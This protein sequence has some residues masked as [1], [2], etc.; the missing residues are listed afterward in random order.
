MG[1]V[2]AKCTQCGANIQIDD[3]KEAGIC[4]SCGTAFITEKAIINY[5]TSVVNNINAET[6]NIVAGNFQ[7]FY[8]MGLNAFEGN[9]YEESYKYFCKALE[10]DPGNDNATLYC[11]LARGWMTSTERSYMDYTQ[12]AFS[13]VFGR[14]HWE[15]DDIVLFLKEYLSLASAV[16]ATALGFYTCECPTRDVLNI[17]FNLLV[18]SIKSL[19][20]MVKICE[21]NKINLHANKSL[22]IAILN[23]LSYAYDEI[24]EKRYYRPGNMG[25]L[26]DYKKVY[27][28]NWDGYVACKKDVD[29][30]LEKLDGTYKPANS[31]GCYIAT[32]IYGS[33]DCPQ[34]W[35]LRRYRDFRLAKTQSG[36]R[37]IKF[38]YA[39]SPKLVELFGE[40]TWF[41]NFWKKVLDKKVEKLKKD[42]FDDKPYEDI[43]WNVK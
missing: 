8:T 2:A 30:K 40:K 23:K 32:C 12:K 38:Y 20:Q 39:I 19:D 16:I 28:N 14:V 31:G 33:Y 11:G 36:Q 29:D 7:N 13:R 25:G 41:R 18:D 4:P 1:L 21:Q 5:N 26:L 42:G 17:V 43:N 34:V 24:T 10:I 22:Y 3:T 37:A 15:E 35:V 27:V 9:D 6:V